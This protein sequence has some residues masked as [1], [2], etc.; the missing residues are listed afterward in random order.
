M[1]QYLVSPIL[2]SISRFYISLGVACVSQILL[3]LSAILD[4]ST[5]SRYNYVVQVYLVRWISHNQ[6]RRNHYALKHAYLQ[7]EIFIVNGLIR[8]EIHCCLALLSHADV[9][10]RKILVTALALQFFVITNRKYWFLWYCQYFFYVLLKI[11]AKTFR[12]CR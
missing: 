10:K 9:N 6:E 11:M 2:F 7:S 5:R 3:S 4:T 1:S 8:S 12:D